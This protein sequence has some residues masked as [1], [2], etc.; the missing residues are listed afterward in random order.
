[1]KYNY[2]LAN[3]QGLSRGKLCYLHEKEIS[4]EEIY[5]M[6]LQKVR[7]IDG[8]SEEEA[9]AISK[10]RRSW[11]VDRKWLELMEQGIGFVCM[12]QE[13]FPEKLKHIPDPPYALYYI[14]KL[15][16]YEQKSVAIVGAR[17]RSAYGSEMTRILAKALSDR[18]IQVI[19]GMAKGID[20]DAHK[21]ALDGCGETYAVLGCGADVCYPSG[22]RYLYDEII[23]RGGII[24]EYPPATEPRPWQFPARNRIIS[25]L[26]DC[27]VVMEAKE[28]SGSLI[29]A[30]CAME[31]GRDVYALPGRTTDPLSRGCNRLIRQGAGI[32]CSVEDFLSELD[33]MTESSY[34]QLDFRKNV[35]EKDERLVYSLT[36]FRPVG[37]STL[38]DKTNFS[39]T[40]LLEIIRRLED[41]GMIKETFTN[42]YV[43]TIL[44]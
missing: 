17:A 29:T 14:G 39:I 28:K 30:D 5:H 38:M 10:S 22:H 6:P 1:M 27:V 35:L 42:Y 31:Q 41:M 44:E 16:E 19:S 18:G 21:G 36:D 11:D 9:K 2:W 7:L 33:I 24:S 4:A 3:V 32:F 26:S 8:I 37:L 13:E 25:G 34:A 15:P 23:K 40:R 12:G 20:A 43:R